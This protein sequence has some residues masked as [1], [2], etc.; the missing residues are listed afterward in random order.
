MGTDVVVK[1]SVVEDLV[2]VL[3]EWCQY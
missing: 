3:F 2:V 1:D